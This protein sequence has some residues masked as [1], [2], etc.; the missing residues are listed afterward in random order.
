MSKLDHRL[1]SLLRHRTSPS[2]ELAE[3]SPLGAVTEADEKVEVLIRG[4]DAAIEARLLE[5]GME[6]WS[7]IPGAYSVVAGQVSI[8]RLPLLGEVEGVQ[9][10]EA[11]RALGQE[12][13]L[14]RN[15]IRVHLLHS[16]ADG[17]SPA[18]RGEGVIV[19][20]I[21]GGI[22]FRH[23]SFR[24]ADGRSRILFLWDQQAAG[25]HPG[26]PFGR[27]YD[28][29]ELDAALEAAEALEL[30][31]HLDPG[32][33][34]THVACIAAGNGAADQRYC[35]VAP[36]ADLIVV[37]SRSEFGTLG[38]SASSQAAYQYIVDKARGLDRPVVI[39]QSQGMNGGGH[40]GES[41]LETAIDNLLR[42]PDVVAVKS[43]GNEQ[44][45]R[46]HASGTLAEG[47]TAIRDFTIQQGNNR[48][49]I[50][51][52]WFDDQDT[53][54]LSL[55]PPDEPALAFV[56][57]GEEAT[58]FQTQAGNSVFLQVD[59]DADDTGDTQ[60]TIEIS[61]GEASMIRPG[62][63]R[64]RLRGDRITEGRFDV[65]I[66]RAHRP[67]GSNR[68]Q[69]QFKPESSDGTRT[70]SIPGT[71]R[72]IV[73]VGSYVT[74]EP[75]V[76]AGQISNFS[77]HG[78]TR[79]GL[80]K[81]SLVAPGQ[82]IIA[83]RSSDSALTSDPDDLHTS[84]PGTSMAAPHVTGAAALILS[85]RPGLTAEQVEQI[86]TRS[87]RTDFFSGSAPDDGWGSGKLDAFAAVEL[88]G[89]A[90]FAQVSNV[91]VAGTDLKWETDVPTT[92]TVRVNPSKRRLLLGR[93]L[94]TRTT[95]SPTTSHSVSVEDLRPGSYFCEVLVFTQ[96]GFRTTDDNQ[97]NCHVVSVA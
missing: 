51:E 28:Q 95:L 88:A 71:A 35:G 18:V 33:H 70:I 53:I 50:L 36:E 97:G 2:F 37:A 68:F 64:L 43:A 44:L 26:V 77:S 75:G 11:S 48:I 27:Q 42:S 5:F 56:S 76:P 30:V 85:R 4:E 89:R 60:A 83:A 13:D 15:D 46:I 57:P 80:A 12:L 62:T 93:A 90:Q 69:A 25:S 16:P 54:S 39:N 91:R 31:P 86:L 73:V 6:V 52:A 82:R 21:D 41:L 61:R 38:R 66:E 22:D 34:G 10:V 84:M 45:W 65:W 24:H 32:G 78:P 47:Q 9:R 49:S 23:P 19:G 55:E 81:P 29:D 20:V 67:N 74:R 92:A 14:A 79:Y 96:E 72:R 87:A 1:R 59:R 63:W 8:E 40:S 94:E 17:A 3:A 7:H 58:E